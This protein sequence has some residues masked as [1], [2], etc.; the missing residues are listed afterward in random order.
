MQIQV[1]HEFDVLHSISIHFSK[2]QLISV[3]WQLVSFCL[4]RF[5]L[6]MVN[7]N[8]L[9]S[10]PETKFLIKSVFWISTDHSPRLNK[11][12]FYSLWRFIK[13]SSTYPWAWFQYVNYVDTWVIYAETR[14]W[15]YFSLNV[16]CEVSIN[17]AL[18]FY[19]T[20]STRDIKI[21]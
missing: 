3:F 11:H 12:T 18:H 21:K 1:Q 15:D 6:F 20:L 4:I 16:L 13:C 17:R 19:F 9:N 7:W 10:R 2:L 5:Y 14:L 8:S